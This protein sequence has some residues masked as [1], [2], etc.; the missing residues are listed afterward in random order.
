[1]GKEGYLVHTE[2]LSSAF[3]LWKGYRIEEELIK[4]E[5]AALIVSLSELFE[6]KPGQY[7]VLPDDVGLVPPGLICEVKRVFI[8]EKWF[9]QINDFS[10]F[11]I[12][13]AV[14][15]EVSPVAPG[16]WIGAPWLFYQSKLKSY[17]V[18]FEV[19]EG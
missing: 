11:P 18:A 13:K 8:E 12:D 5:R 7:V 3:Y 4:K 17:V 15:C 19:E 10:E 14:L 9:D 16:N 2:K 6:F 1:M